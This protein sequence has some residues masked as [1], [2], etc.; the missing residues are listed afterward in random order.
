MG[1]HLIKALQQLR[2]DVQQQCLGPC[3][4]SVGLECWSTTQVEMALLVTTT[5]PMGFWTAYSTSTTA[6]QLDAATMPKTLCMPA[7]AALL[8]KASWSSIALLVTAITPTGFGFPSALQQPST[9]A[10]QQCL[11]PCACLLQQCCS[12]KASWS[13]ASPLQHCCSARKDNE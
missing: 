12:A 5:T 11:A 9:D 8:C 2:A 1:F 3:A 7:A 13:C 4:C 10:E 6:I